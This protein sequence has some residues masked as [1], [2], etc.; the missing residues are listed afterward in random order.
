MIDQALNN[1]TLRERGAKVARRV[2]QEAIIS[3]VKEEI[4]IASKLSILEKTR[5]NILLKAWEN[6]I[7]ENR[8]MAK[9]VQDSCE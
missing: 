5:G 4:V 7:E 2:F 9:E 3:S 6:N 1:I 8:K